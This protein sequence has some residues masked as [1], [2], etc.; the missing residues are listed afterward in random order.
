MWNDSVVTKYFNQ[1][2]SDIT[3][4]HN[5]DCGFMLLRIHSYNSHFSLKNDKN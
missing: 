5:L 2:L 3:T 1:C 4:F